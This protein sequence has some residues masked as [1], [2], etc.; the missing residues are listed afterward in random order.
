MAQVSWEKVIQKN[1]PSMV[2]IVISKSLENVEK[3]IPRELLP[4]FPFLNP[5]K[6]LE[7]M[8]DAHGMIKVGSGSGF[9][10]SS[11]GIILTNKHVVADAKS[12]YTVVTNDNKKYKATILAR[13]PIEDVA[14]LKITGRSLPED[15]TYMTAETVVLV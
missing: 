13:D 14:I 5:K 2:S 1:M 3:E 10:V 4:L 11:K 8:T 15:A 9:I 12:D 7:Q 6:Q